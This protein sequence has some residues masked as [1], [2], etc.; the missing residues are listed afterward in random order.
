MTD[1]E[2]LADTMELGRES[3]LAIA[4]ELLK[5]RR[6]IAACRVHRKSLP[7]RVRDLLEARYPER[8]FGPPPDPTLSERLI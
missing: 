5:A 2:Q 6:F 8:E 7:W 3:R 1:T 4:L